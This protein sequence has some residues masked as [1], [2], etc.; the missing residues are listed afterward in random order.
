MTLQPLIAVNQD[1]PKVAHATVATS[2]SGVSLIN[3]ATF[4]TEANTIII[5]HLASTN[6]VLVHFGT[7][8]AAASNAVRVK[9]GTT[10][11]ITGVAYRGQINVTSV[12]GTPNVSILCFGR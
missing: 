10:L 5:N 3:T 11:T 7:A 2:T 9:A 6:D 1:A 8:T 4:M 12:G